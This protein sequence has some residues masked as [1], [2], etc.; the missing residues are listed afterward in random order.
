MQNIRKESRKESGKEGRKD[1]E[2]ETK[3]QSKLEER[4]KS[5]LTFGNVDNEITLLASENR[6]AIV[7][8]SKSV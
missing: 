3:W 2:K 4:K 5:G 1:C 6:F 7:G 8:F